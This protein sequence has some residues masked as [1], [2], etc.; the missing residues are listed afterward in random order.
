M[1]HSHRT[2]KSK[3]V[4]GGIFGLLG[5]VQMLIS[6]RVSPTVI[7]DL[8]S[9]AVVCA[10]IFGGLHASVLASLIIAAGRILLFG[11]LTE[12]AALSSIS[13]TITGIGCGLIVRYVR[14]YRKAWVYLLTF[15]AVLPAIVVYL[16]LREKSIE[17]IP[18]FLPVYLVG[19][20]IIAYVIHYLDKT[21][22]LFLKYEKEAT[23]DH[24][25]G[26]MNVRSFDIRFNDAVGHAAAAQSSLS[27]LLI[28]IDFFKK[29]NDTYGHQAGDEVLKQFAAVLVDYAGAEHA[30]YRK[31]GEEFIVILEKCPRAHARKMAEAICEGVRGFAFQLPDRTRLQV[32][33]SI[34]VATYPDIGRESLLESADNALYEA[35]RTGRN[36]VVSL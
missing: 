32:T 1:L 19:G 9:L 14:D 10:A 31:G 6:I 5:I 7:M 8:R 29:V 27:V 35:K 3:L 21:K 16:L 20:V 28:D 4:I 12:A 17:V 33:A 34:G 23:K 13:I 30:V 22:S 2:R 15:S 18:V 36:R 25:T 26:L 11:G 24:L